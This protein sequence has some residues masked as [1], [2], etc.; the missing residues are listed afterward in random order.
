[1]TLIKRWWLLIQKQCTKFNAPYNQMKKRKVNGLDVADLMSKAMGHFKV[2][3]K[4]KSFNMV[5]SLTSMKYCPKW[6]VLYSSYDAN[7]K[8]GQSNA[9]DVDGVAPSAANASKRPRERTSSKA[10]AKRD[11]SLQEVMDTV[12]TLLAGKEVPSEMRDERKRRQKDEALKNY[13][14]IQHKKLSLEEINAHNRLKELELALLAEEAKLME[15][16][17]TDDMDPTQRT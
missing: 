5:H 11:A 14:A 7:A 9:I 13:V 17:L 10:E 2:I 3:N 4:I 16:P 1:M 15:D 6:C 12:K 8:P